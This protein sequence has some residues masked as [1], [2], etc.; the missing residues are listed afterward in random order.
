MRNFC[1]RVAGYEQ[2]HHHVHFSVADRSRRVVRAVARSNR[3]P[4][5]SGETARRRP[6]RHA[7]KSTRDQGQDHSLVGPPGRHAAQTCALAGLRADR[8]RGVP[9]AS[10]GELHSRRV[11]RRLAVPMKHRQPRVQNL[12]RAGQREHQGEHPPMPHKHIN[13]FA[14]EQAS[15]LDALAARIRTALEAA[16]VARSNALDRALDAGDALNM[17][18]SCVSSGWKRWLRTNCFLSL[19]PRCFISSSRG[20]VPRSRLR[21]RK[22]AN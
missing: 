8:V 5:R 20:I 1:P 9:A 19:L 12:A 11:L 22:L 17:A 2:S 3:G 18:Q 13:S 21:L 15:K 16:R 6:C 4:L 10:D 14:V 7:Q